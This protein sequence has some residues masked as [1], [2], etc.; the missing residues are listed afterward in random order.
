MQDFVSLMHKNLQIMLGKS[1]TKSQ[2]EL[3]RPMLD[4][5]INLDHELV[6]L[7][8]KIDWGYFEKEFSVYYSDQGAP[9]VPIRLMVGCLLLKHNISAGESFSNINFLLTRAIS[10]T[11]AIV[12]EKKE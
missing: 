11:F 1:P 10:L 8:N 7:A 4:D 3:F 6:R 2:R 12:W 5:F 9:S